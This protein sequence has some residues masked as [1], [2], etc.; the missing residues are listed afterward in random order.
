MIRSCMSLMND[1]AALHS[2]SFLLS[3]AQYQ[4][5]VFASARLFL[6][7][8]PTLEAGCLIRDLRMR[9]IDGIE[10]LQHLR[11]GDI[12]WPVIVITGHGEVPLAVEALKSGATDFIES[13]TRTR[14]CSGHEIGDQL[15]RKG[16]GTGGGE[17]T[18]QGKNC[19]PFHP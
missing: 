4:A 5:R 16:R 3:S 17:G 13:P 9:E 18:A 8:L 15:A 10:L 14:C 7:V 2:L 11:S 1:E 6:D 19:L 12:S